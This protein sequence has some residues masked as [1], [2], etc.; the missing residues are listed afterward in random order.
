MHPDHQEKI[1]DA[2]AKSVNS[3][4]ARFYQHHPNHQAAKRVE[5]SMVSIRSY[6]FIGGIMA[7]NMTYDSAFVFQDTSFS[8]EEFSKRSSCFWREGYNTGT[9]INKY[10]CVY[11]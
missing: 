8:W 7:W 10:T 9:D 5:V 2:V 11:N 4:L 3:A 6:P 1:L